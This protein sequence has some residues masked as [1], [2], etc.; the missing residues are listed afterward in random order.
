MLNK[1]KKKR[2]FSHWKIKM[3]EIEAIEREYFNRY[4]S[5]LPKWQQEMYK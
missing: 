1:L 3:T 4:N 2:S 5:E